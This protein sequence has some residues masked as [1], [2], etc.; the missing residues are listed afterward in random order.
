MEKD[1]FS[2][3]P[4]VEI[5][6]QWY[7]A[8]EGEECD[9]NAGCAMWDGRT[10]TLV[11]KGMVLEG[12]PCGS[13][14][15]LKDAGVRIIQGKLCIIVDSPISCDGCA[16]MGERGCTLEQP[17]SFNGRPKQYRELNP[18]REEPEPEQGSCFKAINIDG[19]KYI[20][21]ESTGGCAGCE[22][23]DKDECQFEGRCKAGAYNVYVRMPEPKAEKQEDLTNPLYYQSYPVET[24]DMMVRIFGK[25]AVRQHCLCTAFKYRMRLGMKGAGGKTVEV[26]SYEAIQKD[27][28]KEQWY[29]NKAKEL[30]A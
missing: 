19:V 25:E 8:V 21:V 6:G 30:E 7:K 15:I 24:I 12:V 26:A 20:A 2:H 18:V 28:A 11:P 23:L 5:K 29:L 3:L 14:Y 1:R 17:C 27:M 22:L 9:S 16:F 13:G 4:T 10:C